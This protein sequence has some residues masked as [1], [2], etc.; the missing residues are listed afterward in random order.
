[1]NVKISKRE[2]LKSSL[3]AMSSLPF[4]SCTWSLNDKKI[5][6]TEY[7]L[8][9]TFHS[10]EVNQFFSFRPSSLKL[11]KLSIPLQ[12]S[13]SAIGHPLKKEIC[14]ILEKSGATACVVDFKQNKLLEKFGAIPGNAF[15]GHG[16][17]VNNGRELL[18]TEY[19]KT[20]HSKGFLVI[21]DG[22][23]FQPK[24]TLNTG[25][26]LPHDL[27]YIA[28]KGVIAIAHCGHFPKAA[29]S[30]IRGAVTFVEWPSGKMIRK[31]DSE[32]KNQ[33]L[34]HV[35]AADDGAIAVAT[36]DFVQAPYSSLSAE[37]NE[38]ELAKTQTFYPSNLLFSGIEKKAKYV[39]AKQ[40]E[41]DLLLT[42]SVAVNS[43]KRVAAFTHV[44]GN[45]LTFWNIDTAELLDFHR[46]SSEAPS[47][48][49]L[50]ADKTK[51]YVST[52]SNKFYVF[53]ANK[54]SLLESIALPDGFFGGPH[55]TSWIV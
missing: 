31:I 36:Q 43:T 5:K 6:E 13:H 11:S 52:S 26:P 32:T 53:D 23:S 14:I 38:L 1:M 48:V 20:D 2:F 54:L 30:N 4:T 33:T 12:R 44:K 28:K 19:N 34:C 50:S 35:A 42:L 24:D 8:N 47:G 49:C 10:K 39:A 7:I 27:T 37:A 45:L 46:F 16:I 22:Q 15:F 25:Y 55:I 3:L 40:I 9:P 29:K 21:R 41:K 18:T 51:F 17:F